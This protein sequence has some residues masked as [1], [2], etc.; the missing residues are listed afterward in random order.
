M[1]WCCNH[2]LQ[3]SIHPLEHHNRFKLLAK[4]DHLDAGAQEHELIMRVMELGVCYDQLQIA[5]LASFE[6]LARR[7]QMLELRDKELI[8]G[9]AFGG[10]VDEYL[11]LYL[12]TGRTRGLMM[13]SPELEEFVA[14]ELGR[15]AAA[16]KER[17][18][19][20][21]ERAS[22]QNPRGRANTTRRELFEEAG[23]VASFGRSKA[24]LAPPEGLAPSELGLVSSWGSVLQDAVASRLRCQQLPSRRSAGDLPLPFAV[25]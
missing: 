23:E 8:T 19:L 22:A 5:E 1:R 9:S 17:R 16:A 6:V 25:P 20:R 18:K 15:E 24:K 10:S 21:E 2:I 14:S 3:H 12:G 11:H 13:V 4:L 7:A